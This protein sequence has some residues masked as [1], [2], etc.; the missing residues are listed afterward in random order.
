MYQIVEKLKSQQTRSSTARTYLSVWR[1]FNRFLVDL[2]EMPSSWEN[3]TILFVAYLIEKGMQSS[4]V[5]SYVSAIKRNLID[6]N[7]KWDEGVVLI[8]SLARA[9][10]LKNDSLCTRLPI[11]CGFLEV[12]LFEVQRHFRVLNQPYLECLYM[13][14]FAI[15]YYG[16]LRVGELT[17]SPHII[18]AKDVHKAVNKDK[19]LIV[20][21]SSK[22]HSKATYPQKIKVTSN[23]TEKTGNYAHR[24]FCPFHLM[25]RFIAM[26]GSYANE[27]E[28]FFV[29]K[30]KSP[31]MVEHARRILRS[32][33][34]K[35]NLDSRVYDMHSLRIGQA[36]DLIK[37]G[38]PFDDAKRLGRWK[39]NAVYKYIRQ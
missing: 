2:D 20:L 14:L 11:Q 3:R 23:R 8:N 22:T 33:I 4:T 26:R 10:K 25:G 1:Q 21:Y 6:D 35:L 7:Y 27:K 39:S 32:M 36:S 9:C 28:Q 29:F 38:Y 18:K 17:L 13:A 19:L 5:K 24:N 12:I 30:D 15:G 37:Y 16:L 34:S 31:V